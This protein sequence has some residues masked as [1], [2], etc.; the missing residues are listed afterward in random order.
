MIPIHRYKY[1]K[2]K[3]GVC[4]NI[5]PDRLSPINKII[6]DFYLLYVYNVYFLQLLHM[7]SKIKMKAN[8]QLSGSVLNISETDQ[9]EGRGITQRMEPKGMQGKCEVEIKRQSLGRLPDHTRMATMS[10]S[11]EGG[12]WPV[13]AATLDTTGKM[14]PFNLEGSSL[15]SPPP[16]LWSLDQTSLS[17]EPEYT[18][19]CT[20]HT[21]HESLQPRVWVLKSRPVST[22]HVPY[23]IVGRTSPRNRHFSQSLNSTAWAS[24]V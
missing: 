5:H 13:R 15:L 1:K 18:S 10:C 20:G 21:L 22:C 23:P 19:G 16:F 8:A 7:T 24:T 11:R 9:E 14:K 2:V 4:Q 3:K 6:G 12:G 17:Q